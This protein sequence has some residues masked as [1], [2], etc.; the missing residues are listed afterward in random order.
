MVQYQL[1]PHFSFQIHLYSAT[2]SAYL[3]V[4]SGESK[5]PL[6]NGGGLDLC[7]AGEA[8]RSGFRCRRRTGVTGV[9]GSLGC[10]PTTAWCVLTA[11][12][13]SSRRWSRRRPRRKLGRGFRCGVIDPRP[14]GLGT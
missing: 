2:V 9:R 8:D 10:L 13:D 14:I 5:R 3:V 6:L 4:F 7:A 12:V 11:I 1:F